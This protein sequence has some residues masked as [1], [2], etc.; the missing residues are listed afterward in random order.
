MTL[1]PYYPQLSKEIEDLS[2]KSKLPRLHKGVLFDKDF[3]VEFQNFGVNSRLMNQS[4]SK[5]KVTPLILAVMK[6]DYTK[7]IKLLRNFASPN[8]V[9]FKGFTAL[10]HAS[11]RGDLL[12]IEILK[13]FGG[14]ITV[15]THLG[16]TVDDYLMMNRTLPDLPIECDEE[17]NGKLQP[18]SRQ[19]LTEIFKGAIPCGSIY[20]KPQTLT[21]YW[22]QSQPAVQESAN[23]IA[24][25]T[26]SYLF[27]KKVYLK[28]IDLD[29]ERFT[30]GV[31]AKE[32][33]AFGE[34][35]GP[36]LGELLIDRPD[37]FEYYHSDGCVSAESHRSLMAMVN[38]GP[39]NLTI[40]IVPNF[41]GVSELVFYSATKAIKAGE[42]LLT[43]YGTGHRIKWQE[44]K[45]FGISN[46]I[47][48]FNRNSFSDYFKRC[49]SHCNLKEQ[50]LRSSFLSYIKYLFST[51]TTFM[52]LLLHNIF[53]E[54]HLLDLVDY[55]AD[56]NLLVQDNQ[57]ILY[58]FLHITKIIRIKPKLDSL[59][60]NISKDLIVEL[61]KAYK[62]FGSSESDFTEI[63]FKIFAG[64]YKNSWKCLNRLDSLIQNKETQKIFQYFKN[65][66]FEKEI[67][68]T[69]MLYP[70]I[71]LM[72]FVDLVKI[73]V[74][75]SKKP[76]LAEVFERLFK[77]F[78]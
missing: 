39:P 16:G 10:H 19:R 15:Q 26:S 32:D 29:H 58:C 33:I 18:L 30:Y 6:R 66:E 5:Y 8:L 70:Q 35:V 56:F 63:K 49:R 36:Y 73:E 14:V 76:Q 74:A 42:Q 60:P 24:D 78:L 65:R 45:E 50:V 20:A 11:L 34:G 25:P 62:K 72:E 48:F 9:D 67:Y 44:H 51:P 7:A 3:L 46:L 12:M 17:V 21:Y 43:D 28:K 37:S 55:C 22:E 64:F 13:A 47:D 53:K 54:K 4:I 52:E 41:K 61:I 23:L 1:L 57:E 68:S 40:K 69:E 59:N 77:Q 75:I 2:L 71:A 31:F 27:P 38:D